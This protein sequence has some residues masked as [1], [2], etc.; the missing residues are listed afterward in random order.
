L[1]E[2]AGKGGGSH[3]NRPLVKFVFLA[4]ESTFG[5]EETREKRV[6]GK[7]KRGKR[8]GEKEDAQR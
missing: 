4:G 5:S 2:I 1:G 7:I 6:Q 8:S 3:R